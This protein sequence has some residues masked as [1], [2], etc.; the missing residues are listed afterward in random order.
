M[1]QFSLMTALL[2]SLFLASCAGP[3]PLGEDKTLADIN[4]LKL[5][6]ISNEPIDV[7]HDKV[8]DSYLS[9]LEVSTDSEMR[10]RAA[11][12][13]ADL[14]F[15]KDRL[16]SNQEVFGIDE[17]DVLLAKASIDDYHALLKRFPDRHDNDLLYYQLAKAYFVS[18]RLNQ[19]IASLQN[20]LEYFP[21]SE[22]VLEATFRLGEMLFEVGDFASSAQM[23]QE[24]VSLGTENNPYY[25]HAQYLTGWSLYRDGRYEEGLLSFSLFLDET[26]PDELAFSS[27]EGERLAMLRDT[28]AVMATSF[29]ILGDWRGI[30]EFYQQH[31]HRFYE[32]RLYA[33][34]SNHY[35]EKEYYK[36]SAS[37][38]EAFTQ[39]DPDSDKAALFYRRLIYGYNRAN[40]PEIEREHK[41]TFIANYPVGGEYWANSTEDMREFIN[42]TLSIYLWNL[43]TFEHEQ[44]QASATNLTRSQ[45]F[46][47]AEK[48]YQEYIR[49]FPDADDIA[50][51]HFLLAEL[52]FE[53]EQYLKAKDQYEIVAYQFSDYENAAEAGYAALLS[54]DQMERQ[55]GESLLRDQQK[56]TSALRFFRE[57]PNDTRMM[58]VLVNT[59]E[60]FIRHGY[61]ELALVVSR[62][63][64]QEKD[65][66][67]N[68]QDGV[69]KPNLMY[70]ASLVRGHS[71]F[72]LEIYA[73]AEQALLAAS[74]Y[75]ELEYDQR[76]SLRAK[77]AAAI[78]RQGEEAREN[79]PEAAIAHWQRL[80]LNIP[81]SP[82]VET[83]DYDVA[84][85][86]M[87]LEAYPR[88]EVALLAFRQQHPQSQYL[89]DIR[90][91]LIVAYESQQKWQGAA[92]ELQVIAQ[93]TSLGK[94]QNRLALFQSA[95][96]FEK[97]NDL[98]NAISMYKRYAHGYKSPFLA[99]IEAHTKL[100]ELY[101]KQGEHKKRAF[102]L[103]K[104]IKRHRQAG[105]EQ[106]ERSQYL[107]ARA[108]FILAEYQRYEFERIRLTMPISKSIVRKNAPMQAAIKRYSEALSFNVQEYTTAAAY[109]MG[110][111]YA[112]FAKGLI[113]S[114][115]PSGMDE[116]EAEEYQF[117]L[118]DEAFP[119]EEAAISIH[120]SNVKRAYEGLY[121]KWV[122]ESY[123]SLAD[124]VPGQFD[125]SERTV[126]Y[127]E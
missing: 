32:Y 58:Q 104:I 49:S 102:W 29:D 44:N 42:G 87:N 38:L 125:K 20:L 99:S 88:A 121:D 94:E 95:Q 63:A 60:L 119:L 39:R 73:E 46:E 93:D 19:S 30:H 115:R 111:M 25:T 114:E 52:Y 91:S 40:F 109:R 117:L 78:Y 34:L 61:H 50:A 76:N 35:Y 47:K 123:Q 83:A 84:A 116:L 79:Q 67:I 31:G 41:A 33:E 96:Y 55:Q 70:R 110:D 2:L 106:T 75:K 14:K 89:D 108:A 72:E 86:L 92:F 16:Q 17:T 4:R 80:A 11:H 59:S 82:L 56:A 112:Q 13:I 6:L 54:Y 15:E 1:R 69:N 9:Y 45:S 68:E 51:V 113:D 12:R 7:D 90:N 122:R 62:L 28:L 85:L 53:N 21:Q 124:L 26:Y 37:T 105:S 64:L 100:D 3:Q 98:T 126:N 18:G 107:A 43:A 66:P 10:I 5:R 120:H 103:D 74:E 101:E 24:V 27:S 8:I 81:E 77:V 71:A 118:E 65:K 48:W 23:Y 57:Y 22:Y 127:A 97:A 36:N